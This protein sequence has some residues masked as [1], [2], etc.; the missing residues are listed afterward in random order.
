MR[1]LPVNQ[2]NLQTKKSHSVWESQTGE[3]W[4]LCKHLET[5]Q[6]NPELSLKKV[7]LLTD[8]L[9]LTG[10]LVVQNEC[11]SVLRLTWTWFPRSSADAPDSLSNIF[12][13]PS[14]TPSQASANGRSANPKGTSVGSG[15]SGCFL[16]LHKRVGGRE[17][18]L[19]VCHLHWSYFQF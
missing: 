12:L 6:R 15:S 16:T 1:G 3:L 9:F 18:S 2:V 14:L 11:C 7:F 19:R 4:D 17:G 10:V 13:G 5:C 8:E